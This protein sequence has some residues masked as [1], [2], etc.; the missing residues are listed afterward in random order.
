M[1][2]P[3][4]I[5]AS[6]S[7]RRA[8]LLRMLNL[9]IEAVPADVDET[10]HAGEEPGEHAERLA[11]EKVAAIAPRYPGALVIGSDTVV[12]VDGVVLGKPRD[13]EDAVAML[14]QLQGREHEV[15]TGVAVFHGGLWSAVERVRVRFRPF[16]RMTAQAYAATGEPL[17]KAGAYGIQGLGATLVQGIAGDYFAVMGLP[18]ARLVTLLREAGYRYHFQGLERVLP[19]EMR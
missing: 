10:Y 1:T 2:A 8:Q 15:A 11:C 19:E 17:D 5:L 3:R 16:D 13:E 7:P 9:D 6:Q 4:I 12:A 14:M 18:I